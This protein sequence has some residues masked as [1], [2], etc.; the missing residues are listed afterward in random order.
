M[1]ISAQ[2]RV[3]VVV[4]VSVINRC[5]GLFSLLYLQVSLY[6]Q[7]PHISIY[8]LFHPPPPSIFFV[9]LSIFS[10]ASYL[11]YGCMYVA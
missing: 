6:R 3:P 4:V 10:P 5:S 2:F 9:Y 11:W 1:P 8:P 7:R